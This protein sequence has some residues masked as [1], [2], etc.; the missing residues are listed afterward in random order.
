MFA[1]AVRLYFVANVALLAILGV[2]LPLQRPGTAAYAV[3]L[4]SILVVA[5]S[6]LLSGAVIYFD[7]DLPTVGGR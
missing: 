1:Q 6:V 5:P 2:T 4:A 3:T 7:V